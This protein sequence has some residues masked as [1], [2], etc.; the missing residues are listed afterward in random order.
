MNDVIIDAL[1]DL[2]VSF[3]FDMLSSQNGIYRT[4][5]C[6]NFGSLKKPVS[7]ST[8]I[9]KVNGSVNTITHFKVLYNQQLIQIFLLRHR[10]GVK[11]SST[12][13]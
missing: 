11:I 4:I 13:L 7:K 10:V 2:F 12:I 3:F 1:P 5:Y 6:F 9:E 8:K